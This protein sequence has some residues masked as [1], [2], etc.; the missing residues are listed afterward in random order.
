MCCCTQD[1]DITVVMWKKGIYGVAWMGIYEHNAVCRKR[2]ITVV[3]TQGM[4][5]CAWIQKEFDNTILC[6]QTECNC[7]CN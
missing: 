3:I 1:K 6:A 2:T 4:C 7:E 5:C